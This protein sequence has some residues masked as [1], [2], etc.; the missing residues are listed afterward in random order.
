GRTAEVPE[1]RDAAAGRQHRGRL[2]HPCAWLDPVP[3]LGRDQHLEPPS[4]VI[5][6]LEARDLHFKPLGPRDDG[7]PRICL[8]TGHL[9]AT[10]GEQRAR[11]PGA[12]AD[13][14]YAPCSIRQQRVHE[15]GWVGRPSAIVEAR[16]APEGLGTR[17][18]LEQHQPTAWAARS[19]TSSARSASAL[20][21]SSREWMS[22]FW[23]TWRRGY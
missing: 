16:H 9:A 8:H 6:V 10:R 3:R 20:P 12:T 14:E 11:D 2:R 13:V 4:A 1:A 5:P 21:S 22:S 18:V 7:H 19:P 15:H 17:A 23:Y